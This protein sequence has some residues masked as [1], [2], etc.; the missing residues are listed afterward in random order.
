MLLCG[1]AEAGNISVAG[2][3]SGL[4]DTDS[5][6]TIAD[7]E[8]QDVLNVEPSKDGLALKKRK[9]YTAYAALTIATSPVRG[10]IAFKNQSGNN[11][12]LYAHDVFVSASSN[13]G[14]FS[15]IITSAPVGSKW[16]FCAT[17]GVAYAFNH[18]T[19]SFVPWSY[20]GTSLTYYPAMPKASLCATT[21]D[22][23]LLAG[24][25]DYPNRLYFSRSGTL[26]DFV[27]D[28]DPEDPGFEDIGLSGEKITA[29]FT[30]QAEWLV[31]KSNSMISYQGT[32]QFD[33][34]PS[35]ISEKIGMVDPHAIVQHEGAVYFKSTS[36]KIYGYA[37]GT[38]NDLSTK[39]QGTISNITRDSV[40]TAQYTDKSQFDNGTYFNSTGSVTA[41]SVDPVP[42]TNTDTLDAD[43]NAGTLGSS[44]TVSGDTVYLTVNPPTASSWTAKLSSESSSWID[45]TS[46]KELFVAVSYDGPVMTSPDGS[47]WTTRTSA[48]NYYWWG[49]TYGEGL[50]VAVGLGLGDG[51]NKNVMTSPDGSSWTIRTAGADYGWR[52]VAYGNGIFVAVSNTGADR[53]MVSATGT[54]WSAHSVPENNQWWDIAYGA[55]VFVA[56]SIDGNNR[57]MTT[58]DGS[59]WTA[60]ATP[61]LNAWRSIAYGNG[62]F[63]AVGRTGNN[64]VMTSPD[65][66]TWT[67]RA[68]AQYLSWGDV[69]YGDGLFVAVAGDYLNSAVMTSPDGITWTS[70]T[71]AEKNDWYGVSYSTSLN[72]FAA[73]SG[74]GTNKVMISTV[75][76]YTTTGT[77]TSQAH[78]IVSSN[79]PMQEYYGYL[80]YTSSLPAGTSAYYYVQHASAATAGFSA[81]AST[82]DYFLL[83]SSDTVW[84][85]QI[86]LVKSTN[87]IN[88]PIIYNVALNF[89]TTGYWETPEV[90]NTGMS[91]WGTFQADSTLDSAASLTY[92]IYVATFSGGTASATPTTITSGA[93]ITASTGTHSKV[94]ATNNFTT[95][96]ETVKLNNLLYSWSVVPDG[97]ANAF[98][99]QGDIYFSVPYN[100]SVSNNRLLRLDLINNGWSVFDLAVNSPLSLDQ[101][102]YFGSPVTGNIY[103]YPSGDSDNGSAIN[104]YWK[105]K[106]Y[107]GSNPYVEKQ[108]NTM[109][110]IMGSD[111]GS[112]LDIS[113]T[114]DTATTTS[115]S[116]ALTSTTANFVRNNRALP[117][118][119]IGTFFNL[120]V[121]NNVADQPW[122]FYGASVDYTD[123]AWRVIPE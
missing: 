73:V 85:Y 69:A 119:N 22:R 39:I 112:S 75:A 33:L 67:A 24:T 107:I 110:L 118:G 3:F 40:F 14:A 80:T 106:N 54:S 81:R 94:R 49:I 13:G 74:Q 113:Y 2:P 41:G 101:Y 47:S 31:F 79:T 7:S 53:S 114:M 11:I 104:S 59:N 44:V 56:V 34:S 4:N 50:F 6:I 117:F 16:S 83:S 76:F 12:T 123:N 88:T 116:I 78:S 27:V 72:M 62:L 120:Q 37:A 61:G 122:T 21:V 35:V 96:T 103:Q 26:T 71:A 82:T 19:F 5:S 55:G 9:G 8:A 89:K 109:S 51:S 99:Y 29:I 64:R 23:L 52:S 65:G 66:I 57:V 100:Y 102:V 43:F 86:D 95:A 63:V 93:T 121:G 30:T 20:D 115:F 91:D 92:D 10:G 38:L 111:Y 105:S 98:E 48:G 42:Y 77:F 84:K 68:P 60:R 46:A 17:N 58:T 25:T 70:Q 1:R 108:F 45:I 18:S 15:N 90:E 87:A 32:N 36:G 97:L 28:V